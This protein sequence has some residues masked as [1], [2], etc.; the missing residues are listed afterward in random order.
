[1]SQNATSTG[2]TLAENV[3]TVSYDNRRYSAVT[4]ARTVSR[5]GNP[6]STGPPFATPDPQDA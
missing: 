6:C 4:A 5:C 1:M 3:R 2:A